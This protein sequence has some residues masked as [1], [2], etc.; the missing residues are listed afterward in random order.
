MLSD[1]GRVTLAF[2]HG[3]VCAL[4]AG[5]LMAQDVPLAFKASPDVY[6]VK[7]E[8]E[9]LRVIEAT[10]KPGQR[11]QFHGHPAFGYYWITDCS[12]RYYFPNGKTQDGTRKAGVF[13]L[14]APVSS[15]SV[16]N[17]GTSDCK[18]VMFEAKGNP[19]Q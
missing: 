19:P 11:D 12:I 10:W 3:I 16:E 13:G 15:H 1:R 7:A 5:P 17:V 4:A 6:L 14:G 18:I 8:N 2:A 9:Q